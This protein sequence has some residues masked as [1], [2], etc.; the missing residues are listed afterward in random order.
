MQF[1]YLL[2]TMLVCLLANFLY[3]TSSAQTQATPTPAD[4]AKITR[5]QT[6]FV[7]LLGPGVT[8]SANYDTRFFKKHDG[9]GIRI[10]IGYFVDEDLTLT[11]FPVQ[12]NYLLGKK[13]KFFEIGA[14]ATYASLKDKNGGNTT[15][16]SFGDAS[17]VIGSLTF[18][19]RYQPVDGGFS[20]RG[21]F[22][23]LFNSRSFVP[24]LGLSFGYTF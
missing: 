13:G 1:N 10:G 8:F 14:G 21:S 12:I 22:N 16:L 2:K 18:G 7:E 17:T 15:V 6:L 3:T 23:P 11:T 19:Y 5:P 9:L 20:F 24:Y 4:S